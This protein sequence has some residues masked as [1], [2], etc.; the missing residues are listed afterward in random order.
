MKYE[1]KKL[2]AI[3]ASAALLVMTL[4]GQTT[5]NDTIGHITY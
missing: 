4:Y 1:R 5:I 3:F 2:T